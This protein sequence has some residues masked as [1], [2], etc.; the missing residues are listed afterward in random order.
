MSRDGFFC[1]LG[2]PYY[3]IS[4]D[5]TIASTPDQEIQRGSCSNSSDHSAEVARPIP[6]YR[7]SRDYSIDDQIRLERVDTDSG[8]YE[9]EETMVSPSRKNHQVQGL[10]QPGEKLSCFLL[11]GYD[12]NP[13]V[14]Q[15]ILEAQHEQWRQN[16]FSLAVVA[17][18]LEQ[19]NK[20]L[21]KLRKLNYQGKFMTNFL[22]DYIKKGAQD[23]ALKS[24][25][26]ALSVLLL[27]IGYKKKKYVASQQYNQ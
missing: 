8:I 20:Q 26:K 12:I 23:N 24:Q 21:G 7:T 11:D 18:Y 10:I 9:E 19:S 25:R 15:R 6:V 14:V 16:G 5:K 3:T 13:V 22:S 4:P 1:Q 17:S 27:F 2:K